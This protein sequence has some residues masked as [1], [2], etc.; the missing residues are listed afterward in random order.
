[1][2][3]DK[4]FEGINLTYFAI[5]LLLGGEPKNQWFTMYEVADNYFGTIQQ[6]MKDLDTGK[7]VC[8][9]HSKNNNLYRFQ[10]KGKNEF[11]FQ[12]VFDKGNKEIFK[13]DANTVLNKIFEH[14][15][16]I[17]MVGTEQSLDLIV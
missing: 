4:N 9:E 2:P 11:A 15:P 13:V 16:F 3:S 1:M 7:T 5:G 8:Y 12:I 17:E 6:F 10:K 14:A